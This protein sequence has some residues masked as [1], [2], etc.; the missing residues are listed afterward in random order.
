M[1]TDSPKP[2]Q[3]R[4][5]I[6]PFLPDMDAA[7]AGYVTDTVRF[8]ERTAGEKEKERPQLKLQYLREDVEEVVN[9]WAGLDRSM[10]YPAS[11]VSNLRG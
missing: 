10:G 7:E 3:T 9:L 8:V 6:N 4:K 5:V 2:S 11:N 1:C